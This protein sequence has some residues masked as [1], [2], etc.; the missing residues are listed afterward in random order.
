MRVV[1]FS[2]FASCNDL[3]ND[4][5]VCLLDQLQALAI[6]RRYQASPLCLLKMASNKV[7]VKNTRHLVRTNSGVNTVDGGGLLPIT[8]KALRDSKSL[9]GKNKIIAFAIASEWKDLVVP[10]VDLVATP[11]AQETT[12]TTA[13]PQLVAQAALPAGQDDES[14]ASTG[15]MA[16]GEASDPLGLEDFD[17]DAEEAAQLAHA[18]EYEAASI[19]VVGSCIA[20]IQSYPDTGKRTKPPVLCKGVVGLIDFYHNPFGWDR[21]F[22]WKGAI[23]IYQ[24]R[25]SEDGLYPDQNEKIIVYESA[26][27]EFLQMTSVEDFQRAK[28]KGKDRR[29][30]DVGKDTMYRDE[31]RSNASSVVGVEDVVVIDSDTDGHDEAPARGAH[32]QP[33]KLQFLQMDTGFCAAT[34]FG[35]PQEDISARGRKRAKSAK[36]AAADED[37]A[38]AAAGASIGKKSKGSKMQTEGK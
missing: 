21:S 16:T 14:V 26:T 24:R 5:A 7:L 37:S 13:A 25:G 29:F 15:S 27:E 3:T 1:S 20:W 22:A 10:V 38:V 12:P 32:R 9:I 30:Y 23:D 4:C 19:I 31:D 6:I 28:K 33:S 35:Q 18:L 36:R 8:W 11:S 17:F 34:G 2:P